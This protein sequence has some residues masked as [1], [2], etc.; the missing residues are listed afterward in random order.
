MVSIII[1]FI[2][3][4]G[5]H[6][7]SAES[8]IAKDFG[9]GS[10]ICVCNSTHCDTLESI[11]KVSAP[12]YIGYAS[13]KEGLR[14]AKENGKFETSKDD[15]KNIISIGTETFQEIFGFG[16]AFTDSTGFNIKSLTEDL[17]EKILRAYYTEEGLEYNT[18]RVPI[19]G[20]DFSTHG[21]SYC[22]TENDEPDPELKHFNLTQDDYDYKIPVI[23]KAQ[24]LT[25]GE[26]KLFGAAWIAPDWMKTVPGVLARNSFIKE[27]MYQ[28]WADYVKKFL[29]FYKKE[30][31]SF[32]GVSTGNEPT[33]DLFPNKVPS[34]AWYSEQMKKW[35]R[36][37]LGPTMRSSDHSDIKIMAN[38]DSIMSLPSLIEQLFS[39]EQVKK[40]VDGTAVHWYMDNLINANVLNETHNEFPDKFIL[41]TEACNGYI[42]NR[43]ILGSWDGAES[44]AS[45]IIRNLNHW[46]I[47]WTDWNMALNMEGGP[48]WTTNYVDSPIIVNAEE[49]EFYKQPYFYALGHF[50]KFFTR[51]S[52]RL[53]VTADVS[54]VEVAAVKRP[55][56]GVAVVILNKNSESVDVTLRNEKGDATLTLTAKSINSVIYW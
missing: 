22:D 28:S 50:S 20:T 4:V 24:E 53:Q 26:L 25:K 36:E 6:I 5:I 29:D 35:I 51:N 40:Y 39:D 18:G 46:S 27:E 32:W 55:D 19:G 12:N 7:I 1:R 23:Q 49:N 41:Y 13:N 54:S 34:I 2:F 11:A 33:T 10:P 14:F 47:G 3:L 42:I 30:G 31:I 44:Y 9:N 48:T 43:P 45:N 15:A 21:Y 16:G 56:N 38:D 8:C 52:V 37:N 17:Q